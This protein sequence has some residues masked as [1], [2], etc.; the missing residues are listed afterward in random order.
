[1][2]SEMSDT[3]PT[4]LNY[5]GTDDVYTTTVPTTWTPVNDVVS[6]TTEGNTLEETIALKKKAAKAKLS[7]STKTGAKV[8]ILRVPSFPRD[9]TGVSNNET[10]LL[11]AAGIIGSTAAERAGFPPWRGRVP[12]NGIV[13]TQDDIDYEILEYGGENN[14]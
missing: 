5:M 2:N 10:G 1:M 9:P 4:E 12:G 7:A 8:P 13:I 6:T 11:S 14:V 3:T